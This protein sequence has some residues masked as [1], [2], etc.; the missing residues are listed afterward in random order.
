MIRKKKQGHWEIH[1]ILDPNSVKRITKY[2]YKRKAAVRV[3]LKDRISQQLAGYALIEKDLRNVI[4]WLKEI[5]KLI[6]DDRGKGAQI[7][8]DRE[9]YMIVKGLFVSSLTFYGKCFTKCEGRK[10]K[11]DRRFVSED[12]RE[13]H[14]WAMHLRHNFAAHSGSDEF[15]DVKIA[16][17]LPPYNKSTTIE[18]MIFRE[19][20]QHDS[21]EGDTEFIALVE[22]VHKDV[23]TKIN[24]LIST[25]YEKEVLP[26]GKDYW[27]KMG[28]KS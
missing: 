23:E 12:L 14:D 2:F 24:K 28:K 1:E 3:Q 25:I 10:I 27:Y 9:R 8:D 4:Y 15:E 16:L 5:R 7:S 22:S 18:P 6:G 19:I 21:S 26:K 17:V 13:C 11:L 20:M